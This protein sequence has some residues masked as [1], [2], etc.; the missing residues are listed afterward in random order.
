MK[1]GCLDCEYVREQRN[2]T[3]VTS[4][5]CTRYV[6]GSILVGFRIDYERPK[7]ANNGWCQKFRERR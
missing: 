1:G 4:F 6:R 5:F 7:V 3:G 2:P